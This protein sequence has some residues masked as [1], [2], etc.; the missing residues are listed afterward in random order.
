MSF[1][2]LR[3]TF[4]GTWR[5]L[6]AIKLFCYCVQLTVVSSWRTLRFTA[7]KWVVINFKEW[8]VEVNQCHYRPGQA[9]R[10]PG[11]SGSQISR[12]S[13]HEG[14]KVVSPTHRP[15]LPLGNITVTHFCQRL[16]R[17]QVQS[18]AGRFVRMKISNDTIG[19]RMR[20]LTDCSPVPEPTELTRN[21]KERTI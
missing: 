18:E 14:G 5:P 3:P 21:L 10:V 13:A 2:L 20:G 11:C 7:Q 1:S 16:S 6:R 12:Q 8:T 15:P 4:S 9:L 17:P 19:N